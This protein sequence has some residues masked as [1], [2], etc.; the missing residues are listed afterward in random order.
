MI[1]VDASQPC[2]YNTTKTCGSGSGSVNISRHAHSKAHPFA[3]SRHSGSVLRCVYTS[4][5]LFLRIWTTCIF[6]TSNHIVVPIPRIR[7]QTL[8]DFSTSI[9]L[10]VV[11]RNATCQHI[12]TFVVQDQLFKVDIKMLESRVIS[13]YCV[14]RNVGVT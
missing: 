6:P 3:W 8:N 2:I 11:Q 5:L 7:K 4:I 9:L 13:S 10:F 12:L 14:L 1:L